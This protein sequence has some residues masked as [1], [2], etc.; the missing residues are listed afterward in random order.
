[1]TLNLNKFQLSYQENLILKQIIKKEEEDIIFLIKNK[2][3]TLV[4]KI[5]FPIFYLDL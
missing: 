5:E 4:N 1:M 3:N 2:K